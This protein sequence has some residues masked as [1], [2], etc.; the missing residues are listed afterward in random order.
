MRAATSYRCVYLFTCIYY[1]AVTLLCFI[2]CYQSL[3]ITTVAY[4]VLFII[5][6]RTLIIGVTVV[7]YEFGRG[8]DLEF[9]RLLSSGFTIALNC[10]LSLSML[11]LTMSPSGGSGGPPQ[12]FFNRVDV[13]S[14]ILV[15]FDSS[16][17]FIRL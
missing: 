1:T 10:Y 14:S 15:N 12:I 3:L 17:T 13:I 9:D 2:A 11:M 4:H 6:I 16:D 7:G 8:G 5:I